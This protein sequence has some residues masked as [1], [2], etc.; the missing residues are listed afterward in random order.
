MLNHTP[1]KRQLTTP[2]LLVI[3]QL[4]VNSTIFGWLFAA[5]VI[6][7]KTNGGKLFLDL[8]LRDQRGSEII[9]RYFDPPQLETLLPQEGKV[10]LLEGTIEEY[11]SQVQI[12]LLR[13]Q[14]DETIPADGFTAGTRCSIVQLE[15]DFQPNAFHYSFPV[16]LR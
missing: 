7:R 5:E 3:S 6:S 12:K 4:T 10:V 1:Q 16:N 15:A 11:R 14:N 8:R 9:A 2:E 13:V